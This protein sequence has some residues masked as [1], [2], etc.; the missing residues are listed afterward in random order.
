[1]PDD[2]MESTEVHVRIRDIAYKRELLAIAQQQA[3][4]EHS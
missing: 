1:M 4:C 3:T 2:M